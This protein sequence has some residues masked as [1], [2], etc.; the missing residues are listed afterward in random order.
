MINKDL[1]AILVCPESHTPLHP[2]DPRLL[3]RLNAA[4][5]A[6]K[7]KNRAGRPVD[8]PV[9]EGLVRAAGDLLY[10]IC[11]GIPV[12]L[13]DEAIPLSKEDTA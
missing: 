9:R 4:I 1:T 7:V 12:M 2:A 3:A 6:G 13:V 10:P 11:D 5:A 8:E